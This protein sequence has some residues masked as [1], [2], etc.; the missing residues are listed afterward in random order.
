MSVATVKRMQPTRFKKISD[1]AIERAKRV[2]TRIQREARKNCCRMTR[3]ASLSMGSASRSSSSRSRTSRAWN[4][5]RIQTKPRRRTSSGDKQYIREKEATFHIQWE[6]ETVLDEVLL[7][8]GFMLDYTLTPRPEFTK[9][10]VL[11]A[12]DAQKES[13][14]ASTPASRLRRWTTSKPIPNTSSSGWS[15]RS[16][17][18]RSGT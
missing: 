5:H 6:R 7:K 3:S 8:N 2:I 16:T 12:K 14:H 1:V 11:L 4:S 18:R 9:N 10:E 17:R 15:C 13:S